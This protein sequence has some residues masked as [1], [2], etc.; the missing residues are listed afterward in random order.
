MPQLPMFHVALGSTDDEVE[1]RSGKEAV[2][3]FRIRDLAT[4]SVRSRTAYAMM[5]KPLS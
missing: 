2:L 4:S 5:R 3:P 1:K